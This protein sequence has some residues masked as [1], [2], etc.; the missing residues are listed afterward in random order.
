MRGLNV[1]W[2]VMLGV[3]VALA[4]SGCTNSRDF[5][6]SAPAR[7]SSSSEMAARPVTQASTRRGLYRPSV[8]NRTGDVIR[9]RLSRDNGSG[10]VLLL[11]QEP[12]VNPGAGVPL[13][14]FVIESGWVLV[15]E[16]DRQA[17]P[18]APVRLVLAPGERAVVVRETEG[19]LSLTAA[20]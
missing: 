9:L 5:G 1:V 3:V 15:L 18:G 4:V 7:S 19:G 16:A 6:S 10:K 17:N 20:E 11:M 8:E 13:G 14:Q 2:F 12:H